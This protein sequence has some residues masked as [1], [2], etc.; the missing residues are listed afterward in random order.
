MLVNSKSAPVIGRV[1]M[2]QTM[3]DAGVAPDLAI[4]DEVVVI[5]SQGG[6]SISVDEIAHKTN[7]I[8]YEV[9]TGVSDRV[10]RVFYN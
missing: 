2:D 5:G 10:Q 6:Q 3:I 4:G 8:S 9:L 1:C 7:T